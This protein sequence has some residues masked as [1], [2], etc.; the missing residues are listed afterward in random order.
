MDIYDYISL[1]FE[2][3]ILSYD[4][5]AVHLREK[6]DTLW[7]EIPFVLEQDSLLKRKYN[8]YYEWDYGK[9]YEF[10]VD[11][12]AF[13]G[14]YGL[15]SDKI[16]QSF[17]VRTQEEYGAIFFNL[18]GLNTTAFLQ[19]LDMQDKVL[20]QVPVIEGKADFYYLNPGK[21]TARLVEDKN[22]NGRWDTGSYEE[23]RQ[24]EMVYYYPQMLELKA[25]WELE[26][27]WNVTAL[28]LD[29]QKL[30][31]LK[32]QKPD[33]DRKKKNRN[34]QNNDRNRRN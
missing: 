10:S 8:F 17:K 13:K 22:N 31:E 21:Y 29:K 24:P 18:S 25:N 26:Q 12:T 3:P 23:K 4:S 19:L 6:V 34:N 28:P 5:G 20:R 9:E 15:F 1:T 30:D 2:E 11:S 14:Q 33:E 27:D 16:K 7:K 32:K